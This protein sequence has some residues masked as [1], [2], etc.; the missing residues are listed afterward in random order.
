MSL[1]GAFQRTPPRMQ[2]QRTPPVRELTQGFRGDTQK[3]GAMLV[4]AARAASV[5]GCRPALPGRL[6]TA[7]VARH[8]SSRLS[9]EAMDEAIKEMNSEM[10]DLF[11]TQTHMD[12]RTGGGQI[13][14]LFG[15]A[16]A[17]DPHTG[18]GPP[19]LSVDAKAQRITTNRIK[20]H[21]IKDHRIGGQSMQDQGGPGSFS[22][23]E[24]PIQ[25]LSPAAPA[26]PLAARGSLRS[27]S[28]SQIERT[29]SH[30]RGVLCGKIDALV[31]QLADAEDAEQS[32][33]LARGV[34]A[35]A[36]ALTEVVGLQVAAGGG[37]EAPRASDA[38]GSDL[39]R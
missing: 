23:S 14:E 28:S 9:P 12:P 26:V 37:V 13:E 30:A 1:C 10:E 38:G 32:R 35:C 7:Y 21:R 24:L 2:S 16:P 22:M 17:A 19:T 11:G 5:S 36:A 31:T 3:L 27:A 34:A 20:D 6:R 29:C 18:G 8:A 25:G 15:S 4:R 39:V 33:T